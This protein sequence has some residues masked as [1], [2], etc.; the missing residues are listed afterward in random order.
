[1][2]HDAEWICSAIS[3]TSHRQLIIDMSMWQALFVY[4]TLL[5]FPSGWCAQTHYA[6]WTW[7][8]TITV[9]APNK[10]R[11]W[12]SWDFFLRVPLFICLH[13]KVEGKY[14]GVWFM[15]YLYVYDISIYDRYLYIYDYVLYFFF[16]YL[17][18]IY[19]WWYLF[20]TDIH[21]W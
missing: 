15:I 20:M 17:F 12:Y 8:L 4:M 13:E 21:L 18:M 19:L 14:G 16:Y 11:L 7:Y 2:N 9:I 1:M 10:D 3:N 6:N 5:T